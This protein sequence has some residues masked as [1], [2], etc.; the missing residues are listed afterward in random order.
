MLLPANFAP[1]ASEEEEICSYVLRVVPSYSGLSGAFA[2]V[3][4]NRDIIFCYI[5]M[6][7]III[8][9]ICLLTLYKNYTTNIMSINKFKFFSLLPT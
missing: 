2:G 3:K 4:L 5:L 6:L 1:F 9:D 7:D 8:L